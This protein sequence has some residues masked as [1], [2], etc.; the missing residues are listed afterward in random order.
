MIKIA[1]V[2]L[3]SSLGIAGIAQSAPVEAHPIVRVGIGFPVIAPVAV[4]PAYYGQGYYSYSPY[5]RP[6]YVRFGH[7]RSYRRWYRR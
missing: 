4:A 1:S 5:W 7:E 2:I 6:G 3:A